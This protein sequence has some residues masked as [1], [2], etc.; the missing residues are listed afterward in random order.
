MQVLIY[1]MQ[2]AEGGGH[3]LYATWWTSS[4]TACSMLAQHGI[5]QSS[6]FSLC[7]VPSIELDKRVKYRNSHS[8]GCKAS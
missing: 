8:S 1:T 5:M 4:F 2:H 3:L 7:S 6:I